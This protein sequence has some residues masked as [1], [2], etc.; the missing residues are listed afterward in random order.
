[1]VDDEAERWPAPFPPPFASAWGDDEFG[2]WAEFE[3]SE[4]RK[5]VKQKLRWIEPG[6][7]WMGSPEDEPERL[8][9]EGPRHLVTLTEGFWL[10]DTACTQALWSAVM[11]SNPSRVQGEQLPVENVSWDDV[12]EFLRSLQQRCEVEFVLPTEAQWEYAC[13]AGTQ[14]AFSVGENVAPVEVNYDGNYPYARGEKGEYRKRT[15][16]V[17]SLPPNLWGL[18]EMHGNVW[19]WC[20]D[21]DRQYAREPASDPVG[22]LLPGP[23]VLRGGSWLVVGRWARSASRGAIEPGY[24]R[25][26][27]GFRLSARGPTSSAR[28]ADC[29]RGARQ[30]LSL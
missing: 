24:C 18:Y 30:G 22:P 16:A 27:I 19:E 14:T 6:T 8:S 2:L 1:V 17:G 3:L 28:R 13:R 12:Q 25:G 4:D 9:T 11:G 10:A 7:Y 5:S 26:D 20:I 23:R 29:R 15:V 21:S